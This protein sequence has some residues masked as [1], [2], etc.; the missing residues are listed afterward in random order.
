[1]GFWYYTTPADDMGSSY[2]SRK[3]CE[4]RKTTMFL[5]ERSSDDDLEQR[6]EATLG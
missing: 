5:S 4:H 3:T 1:M 6:F 2:K